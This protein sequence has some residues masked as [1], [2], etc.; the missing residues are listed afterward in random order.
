MN[1]SLKVLVLLIIVSFFSCQKESSFQGETA[2]FGTVDYYRSFLFFDCDTLVLTK[3]LKY[4]FNDYSI[5]KKSRVTI[6]VVDTAQNI[7]SNK[8]I[9]FFINDNLIENN[10]FILNS[11]D[12]QKGALKI[13]LKFLPDYPEGYT[14]G[15]L[16]VSN[17]SLDVINNNDL[18]SSAEK[19]LFK[20]E[21]THRLIMNPLKKWVMWFGLFVLCA[22]LI[23]FMILRNAMYSKFKKGKIQILSPYFKGITITK[24]T[25]LIV[26]TNSYR[27]QKSLNRLFTG[28]IIYE[29]NPIYEKEVTLRP[30]RGNKIKIKLPLGARISPMVMNMEKFNNY[31]IQIEEE[32][33]EIQ[34]S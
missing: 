6:K 31:T 18:N 9:Q 16:S 25:R 26:F 19:R 1:K 12:T 2:D 4:S 27:K 24:N 23:W 29:V 33:I 11:E 14:S 5:E 15:F 20:W 28:K 13:G 3:N 22:L 34:Y 10:S 17:H 8:Y 21:A 32:K 30:G 7:V